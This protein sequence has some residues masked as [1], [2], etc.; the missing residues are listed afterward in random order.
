MKYFLVSVLVL[1]AH[2]AFAACEVA[3]GKGVLS[4]ALENHP[5]IIKSN[6]EGKI[7]SINKELSSRWLNP[8]FEAGLGYNREEADKRGVELDLAIM[9]P[10][11]MPGKRQ[12]RINKAEAEYDFA[13]TSVEEQKEIATVQVLTILNRLRQ[14][15]KEKRVLDETIGTFSKAIDQYKNRPVLSPEDE[16][17]LDLFRSALNNYRIE[18]NQLQAEEKGYLS[19]LR[20]ILNKD[21]ALSRK[22]FYFPPKVWPKLVADSI[23]NSTDLQKENANIALAKADFLDAKYSN[24]GGLSVG[25]YIQ[26]RPGDIDRV[27]AY[28]VRFSMPIPIYSNK[29]PA[30]AGRIAVKAAE[31]GYEAR[32]R[33]LSNVFDSLKEQYTF[34]VASLKK[35]DVGNIE[36]QHA[37]TE[38]LFKDGRVSNSLLIE[39]HRQMV[40]SVRAYHQYELETLQA[41][42]QVYA[43][44][45]KLITNISEVAHEKI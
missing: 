33:E 27:D 24:F 29:K 31:Q 2:T 3:S 14:I 37:K 25:P 21:V 30:A 32:K 35:F 9:Q 6:A 17:S 12:A 22:L 7:K 8:D 1:F 38:K 4:C 16:I 44:Q 41:L 20:T 43:L 19:N 10:I 5:N 45:R 40:D 11:E 13:A 36:G 34:G 28:G 42:W 15:D 26:T 39:A 23:E 18:R